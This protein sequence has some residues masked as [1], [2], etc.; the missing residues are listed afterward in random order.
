MAGISISREEINNVVGNLSL[1]IKEALDRA[2]ALHEYLAGKTTEDLTSLGFAETDVATI[3]SAMADAAQLAD[4]YYG[5]APIATAK[6]FRVFMKRL[7]G[8]GRR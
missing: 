3:K 5:R 7:Y 8:I 4:V 1:D 6:D 2:V